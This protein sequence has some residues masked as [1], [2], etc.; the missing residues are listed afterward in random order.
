MTIARPDGHLSVPREGQGAAVLVLHAWWGLND[1]V[2]EFCNSLAG[3]SFTAF[4]PD[5]YHGVIAETIP[6]AEALARKLDPDR[7]TADIAS[8]VTFLEDYGVRSDS[9]LAVIGFSLGASYALD[10]SVDDPEHVRSVVLFYGTGGPEDYGR[11][12]AAYAGH[13]AEADQFEPRSDVDALEQSL[14]RAGRPVS[15]CHYLGVG[16]WFFE[17]DRLDAFNATAAG[18]AWQRTVDFLR[19]SHGLKAEEPA[20]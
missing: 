20:A 12:R 19:S 2:R 8:S 4:A 1:V 10:L 13:F 17:R 15:F 9:G 18:L 14:R 7:A 5:L 6:G 16:H 11:S 3:A